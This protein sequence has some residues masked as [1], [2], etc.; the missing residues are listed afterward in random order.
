MGGERSR[1]EGRGPQPDFLA[2]PLHACSVGESYFVT[3]AKVSGNVS[4]GCIQ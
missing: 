4:L 1:T 3:T 2:T